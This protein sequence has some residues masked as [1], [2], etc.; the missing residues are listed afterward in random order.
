MLSVDRRRMTLLAFL[1]L[2]SG[3]DSAAQQVASSCRWPALT[4]GRL[5]RA[6]A[7]APLDTGHASVVGPFVRCTSDL[8]VLGAYAGQEDTA[9][10]VR[11]GWIRRL[12]VR[13]DARK[14][15][16]I[17]GSVA[18]A[19]TFGAVAA[20]RTNVC[21]DPA[22]GVSTR[23]GGPWFRDAIVGAAVGGLV[24]WVLGSGFPHWRRIFP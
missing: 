20:F 9:Y 17:A 16:L 12:W 10:A 18:G 1:I 2:T 15:G 23:C 21:Y 24:G 5:V 11:I 13:D 8:I 3:H 14:S 7:P 4:P 22:T 19:V 6:Q